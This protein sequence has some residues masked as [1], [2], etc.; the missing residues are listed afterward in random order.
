MLKTVAG[1]LAV[2]GIGCGLAFAVEPPADDEACG[3]MLE[4]TEFTVSDRDV[5]TATREKIDTM[6]NEVETHCAAAE[7]ADAAKKIE[8]IEKMLPQ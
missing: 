7:Y 2:L 5:D 3:N 4:A 6:L 8:Q 1:A